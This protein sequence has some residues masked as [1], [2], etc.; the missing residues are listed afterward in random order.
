MQGARTNANAQDP[1]W[2]MEGGMTPSGA[3]FAAK[4]R[5]T[6]SVAKI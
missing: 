5:Q 6:V 3:I 4:W 2:G 1:N